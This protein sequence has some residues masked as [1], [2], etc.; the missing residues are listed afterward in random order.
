MVLA[1]SI[2]QFRKKL[3]EQYQDIEYEGVVYGGVRSCE[4]R[5][6]MIEPHVPSGVVMDI[7]SAQGYF[8]KKMSEK[9]LVLSIEGQDDN[10]ELQKFLFRDNK[11]VV[12]CHKTLIPEMLEKWNEA[13]P[14]VDCVVMMSVLHHFE[15]PLKMLSAVSDFS[16]RLIIE[17]AQPDEKKACGSGSRNVSEADLRRFYRNV[18]SLGAEGSHTDPEIVRPIFYCETPI[19]KIELKPYV[20]IKVDGY[21]EHTLEYI[22]D[23]KKWIL[24]GHSVEEGINLHDVLSLLNVVSP[25]REVI[26]SEAAKAYDD[27]PEATDVR[28]WNLIWSKSGIAVIDGDDQ[29][30]E[31]RR[32]PDDVEKLKQVIMDNYAK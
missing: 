23:S 6:K 7:G 13:V 15:D 2:D 21:N 5:W 17:L 8:A 32:K 20:G 24:D 16:P 9:A 25:S 27:L 12:V 19:N 11:Q 31:L 10:V 18:V 30:E 14:T 28:V 26:A 1:I 3:P 4:R 29:F 22:F